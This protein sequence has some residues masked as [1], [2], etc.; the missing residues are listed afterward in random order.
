VIVAWL[1]PV[2]ACIVESSATVRFAIVGA[3]FSLVDFIE[4]FPRLHADCS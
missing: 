1:Q 3:H 2:A 4:V